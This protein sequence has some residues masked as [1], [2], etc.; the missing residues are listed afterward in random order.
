MRRPILLAA[1][2]LLCLPRARAK[3]GEKKKRHAY[4]HYT[5]YYYYQGQS[6][7]WRAEGGGCELG[8][9]LDFGAIQGLG[10]SRCHASAHLFRPPAAGSDPGAHFCVP[11]K[12]GNRN[13]GALFLFL[14]EGS[15]PTTVTQVVHSLSTFSVKFDRTEPIQRFLFARNPYTRILSQYLNHIAGDCVR[16]SLGCNQNKGSRG[17]TFEDYVLG[18]KKAMGGEN[19]RGG[20]SLCSVDHHLC[21]QLDS[22]SLPCA[23]Q[24][25]RMLKLERQPLWFDCLMGHLGLTWE[26]LTG[27]QWRKF[28]GKPY[29]YEKPQTES[30]M[31][32][33]PAHGTNASGRVGEH[34]TPQAARIVTELYRDDLALL[35]YPTWDGTGRFREDYDARA[36]PSTRQGGETAPATAQLF[37]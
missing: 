22:C 4:H 27:E 33:G 2:C 11:Q 7:A 17:L 24:A 6:H 26:D 35:G 25:P 3:P 12:N 5:Y 8:E 23:K 30:S 19:R 28:A 10:S 31:Y 37:P 15:P 34:Y 29:Y 16:G 32:V 20:K 1:A 18:I 36:Q 13:W 14:H 9:T 21:P